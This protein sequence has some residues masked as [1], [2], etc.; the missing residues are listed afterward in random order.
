M[1]TFISSVISYP[2]FFKIYA[3]AV[4][5]SIIHNKVRAFKK[6]HIVSFIDRSFL[7]KF[8]AVSFIHIL[9]V[10]KTMNIEKHILCIFLMLFALMLICDY[11]K[12]CRKL[13]ALIFFSIR[14]IV[15]L[16]FECQ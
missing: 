6:F 8:F 14:V 1:I 2:Q 13:C 16:V 11:R 4:D 9:S 3:F 15:E 10:K 7:G 5:I 12:I